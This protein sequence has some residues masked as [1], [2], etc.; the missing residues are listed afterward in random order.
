MLVARVCFCR[1]GRQL[2]CTAILDELFTTY[3]FVQ[4]DLDDQSRRH[5]R[6]NR[7]GS[8]FDGPDLDD[9]GDAGFRL[10]IKHL[11][12]HVRDNLLEGQFF[13]FPG[14]P[15]D[16][17]ALNSDE[18]SAYSGASMVD[19]GFKVGDTHVAA[20]NAVR[21]LEVLRVVGVGAKR[22]RT[23]NVTIVEDLVAK[24]V[25]TS[26]RIVDFKRDTRSLLVIRGGDDF[27]PN[28]KKIGIDTFQQYGAPTL[29]TN[30]SIATVVD[31]VGYSFIGV[32]WG[33]K[34][35]LQHV[36]GCFS[37]LM[38]SCAWLAPDRC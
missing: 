35:A 31:K 12:K 24:V 15:V 7:V 28:I 6:E 22:R 2:V 3:A 16:A 21:P 8:L 1:V 23:G 5:A 11:F 27:N 4:D 30:L 18:H 17:P 9:I 37:G 34:F 26:F 38:A 36:N 32:H 19:D 29:E 25:A 20:P 33:P 10:T 13:S 14:R